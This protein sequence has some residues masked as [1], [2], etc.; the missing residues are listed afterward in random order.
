MSEVRLNSSCVAVL[1]GTKVILQQIE[2]GQRG[3]SGRGRPSPGGMG[4]AAVPGVRKTFP[5]REDREHGEATSLGLTEAFLIYG[6]KGGTVEFFCLSE[7]ALLGGVEL[8][9]TSPIKR[10]WPNYLGTRVVFTDAANAGWLYSPASDK[11]TQASASGP[12]DKG[13]AHREH[14]ED[15]GNF[16]RWL[17]PDG[18]GAALGSIPSLD[19]VDDTAC[20]SSSGSGRGTRAYRDVRGGPRLRG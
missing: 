17:A 2:L 3:G 9:H 4:L 16:R 13:R 10:L 20:F 19:V 6:T 14:E 11:I 1:S 7:W 18:L 5:E 15:S 8:K 12:E